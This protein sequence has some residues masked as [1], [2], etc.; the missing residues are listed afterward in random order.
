MWEKSKRFLVL[1]IS[2]HTGWPYLVLCCIGTPMILEPTYLASNAISSSS[3]TPLISSAVPTAS[4][5]SI[6]MVIQPQQVVL[7]LAAGTVITATP[8]P[9]DSPAAQSQPGASTSQLSPSLELPPGNSPWRCCLLL[10]AELEQSQNS[11]V[12]PFTFFFFFFVNYQ[13]HQHLFVQCE[14][15]S[16]MLLT[17]RSPAGSLF[18]LESSCGWTTLFVCGKYGNRCHCYDTRWWTTQQSPM[19]VHPGVLGKETEVV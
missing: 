19:N 14:W 13:L 9:T 6:P 11:C 12:K 17:P 8:A 1:F 15:F 18:E 3:D 10:K 4:V 16:V 7:G 5:A 2:L